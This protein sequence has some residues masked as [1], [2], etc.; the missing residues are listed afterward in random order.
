MVKQALDWKRVNPIAVLAMVLACLLSTGNAAEVEARLDRESVPAGNGALL[1]LKVSGHDGGPPQFPQ[2]KNLI[3]QPRGRS[4]QMQMFNG[5]TTVSTTYTF[6]VGAE[7][8]GDYQIPAIEVMIDGEKYSTQP[9]NLKVLEAGA[10]QP[11]AVPQQQPGQAP[12]EEQPAAETE[13]Q[14]FGFLTVELAN[15]DRKHAF[16]GEIAPVRIRAWL[17]AGAQAQLRSGIQPEG[18]GFTLHNVSEQPRQTQETR[19]GKT[20]TVVTW[21]GGISATRAG[22][23]PA[24]LSVDA[25]VAVRD[26][27]AQRRRSG[28]PFDDPFFGG[29]FD[30][31]PMIEKE[32][33]LK[34]DDQEI[35][36]RPLP[37][38]GKPEGFSGAVGQFKFDNANIPREWKTGEPQQITSQLSGSGNFALMKA[39]VLTP[40]DAWKSYEG[41]DRFQA[42]DETSFSGAKV[43]Q[44][45]AVPRKGG[46]QE[47]SLSFSYFDPEAEAYRTITSPVEKIRVTGEDIAEDEPAAAPVVK[48]PEKKKTGELVAQRRGL[49]PSATLVPLISRPAF[50][51]MLSTSAGMGLL[52]ILLAVI[53]RRR[54][55]PQRL[56][57]TALA[58]ETREA[59]D[60]AGA[61]RDVPAFFAAARVAIQRQLGALWNQPPLAI[62]T[63]E[64]HA[65]LTEDSPVARFFREADRHEYSRQD[66]GEVLPQWRALLDE[67]LTSLTPPTR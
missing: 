28:G 57:K 50:K 66:S 41:K 7:V 64:V 51:E 60:M 29:I 8:P 42:G 52:G 1:T 45:S 24:S 39:P 53:R 12:E 62:T 54:S 15:S 22:K 6:A 26:K 10:A 16:V 49:S 32:M 18:K 37:T 11:Q 30:T 19:D 40:A 33:T 58:K 65:R 2:V 23:L 47:V 43:F 67:A 5:H 4:Q 17:P 3:V 46:E 59:L 44:F 21:F 36:V 35:E 14:E 38:E 25:T 20:Y 61:A 27:S 13:E 48:E 9:L 56:A 34:S 31:T 55:D 63:A